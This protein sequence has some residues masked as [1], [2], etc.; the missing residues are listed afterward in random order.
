[1]IGRK[2]V[3]IMLGMND[4]GGYGVDDSIR[5]MEQLTDRILQKN[6]DVQI[7][8][9]SVTPLIYGM[10]RRDL[11][12]NTNVALFNQ[13]AREVCKEHG[14]VFVDVAS[15]VS[16]SNGNLRYELCGDADY[17]GLHFNNS[18]CKLWVEYLR[19]HVQ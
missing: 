7:Y 14:F 17:M 15:A 18:G 11:L 3:F 1:M 10:K 16:D 13:R 9:Q 5:A 12:N 19:A 4:I 8:I 2:K 6:P